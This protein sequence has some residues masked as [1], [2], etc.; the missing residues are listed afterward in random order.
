MPAFEMTVAAS[1]FSNSS[2]TSSEASEEVGEETDAIVSRSSDSDA[3]NCVQMIRAQ[4][5]LQHIRFSAYVRIVAF[6]V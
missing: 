1:C 5:N 6:T 4:I 2:S 3:N